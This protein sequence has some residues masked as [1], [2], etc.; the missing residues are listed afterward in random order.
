MPKFNKSGHEYRPPADNRVKTPGG[1]VI[2]KKYGMEKV[3]EYE[4]KE[5]ILDKKTIGSSISKLSKA[6]GLN[7]EVHELIAFLEQ[8]NYEFAKPLKDSEQRSRS[9]R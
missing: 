6:L 1:R 3:I 5:W 7:V 9:S 2:Y 4:S 8:N